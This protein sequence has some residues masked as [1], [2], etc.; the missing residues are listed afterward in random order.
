MS[1]GLMSFHRNLEARR[2]ERASA[3]SRDGRRGPSWWPLLPLL[4]F[5]FMIAGASHLSAQDQGSQG[6]ISITVTGSQKRILAL[7]D[8]KLTSSD[9]ATAGL[10]KTFDDVVWNDLYQSGIVRLVSKSFYPLNTP[11]QPTDLNTATLA[12]W[13][14]PPASAQVLAF[15]NLGVVN[16]VLMV[17]GYL[18]NLQQP[19]SPFML[20]KRYT[21]KPTQVSARMIGHEFADAIIAALGGGVGIG[22]SKIVF[23]STAGTRRGTEEVWMMDYDGADKQQITHLGNIA[24]SPK[25]SPDGTKIAFM[26]YSDGTPQIKIYSLLA[27]RYLPF[28]HFKGLNATPAWSPDG[29]KLA[30]A[31]SM[32][33]DVEIYTISADGGGLRRLT[34]SRGV[35]ISPVWNPKTGAQIAFASDRGGLP[36]IYVMDTD[37]TNQTRV[38]TGGY[39]VSPSWSPNGLNLAF[40][41]VRSGGGE[42]SG[43]L[44]VYIYNLATH[45]YIQ[46]THNGQRNDDPSWAPDGRHIVFQSGTPD[47]TQLFT[48]L[49]DGSGPAQLTTRGSNAMPNWS[50]H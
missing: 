27:H 31:S 17:Q 47:R 9:P 28:P 38:T 18:Y 26:S 44:D 21:D 43:A 1:S 33:G 42:N 32:S 39:A 23:T 40:S 14:N 29:A 30:F 12:G 41:W 11:G 8:F 37:G 24:Y 35:D 48:V 16:G 50:F 10:Q 15:G 20:G 34:Y 22:N 25:L 13:A 5:V 7:P 2:T 36:Q 6:P 45:Q 49:A 4:V 19:S 3:A 46:L